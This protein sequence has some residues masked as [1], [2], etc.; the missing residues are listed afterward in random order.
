LYR[1]GFLI[2]GIAFLIG[3]LGVTLWNEALSSDP[4]LTYGFVGIVAA[5]GLAGASVVGR[6]YFVRHDPFRKL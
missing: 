5:P 3:G 6:A 4:W 2:V 1:T